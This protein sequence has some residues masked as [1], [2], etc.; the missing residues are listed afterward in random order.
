MS[1]DF[2]FE[3]YGD[4]PTVTTWSLGSVTLPKS[5]SKVTYLGQ[6]VGDTFPLTGTQSIALGLGQDIT[7]M[8]WLLLLHQSGYTIPTLMGSYVEP[9]LAYRGSTIV[10]TTPISLYNGTWIL[11]QVKHDISNEK[12]A[13]VNVTL[14]FRQGSLNVIV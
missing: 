8:T 11:D 7:E 3:I 5:P 12:P 9:L 4:A 1:V 2:W 10:T 14:K 13:Q 6:G